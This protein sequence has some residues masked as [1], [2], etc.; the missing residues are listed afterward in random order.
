LWY[1]FLGESIYR[2]VFLFERPLSS[3]LNDSETGIPVAVAS[4][5]ASEIGD[6]CVFRPEDD[7]ADVAIRMELGHRCFVA[8]H[9][10]AIVSGCWVGIG[11]VNVPYLNGE[12]LLGN[13]DIY[14]YGLYT[15]PEFRNLNLSMALTKVYVEYFQASGYTRAIS[16]VMPENPAGMR[17]VEKR[18]KRRAGEIGYIKLGPWRHDFCRI[19]PH[20]LPVGWKPLPR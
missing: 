6:Y 3:S 11:R 16:V 8:R 5:T 15:S 14:L 20:S 12:I 18:G 2:R 17:A 13:R 1:R 4:L 10:G 7:P 9:A 19:A